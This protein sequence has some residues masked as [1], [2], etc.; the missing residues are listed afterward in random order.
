MNKVKERMITCA[1][2]LVVAFGIG[3]MNYGGSDEETDP[4]ITVKIGKEVIQLEQGEEFEADAWNDLYVF[5][6]GK[7][8]S[9]TPVIM[10]DITIGSTIEEVSQVFGLNKDNAKINAEV[11]TEEHDGTT[12]VIDVEYSDEFFDENNEYL[13]GLI[14]FGFNKADGQ[15]SIV[16]ADQIESAELVYCIDINGMSD[17]S[18][19]PG[20]VIKMSIKHN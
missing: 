2:I 8:Y 16:P 13:D 7:D 17:S 11:P 12:D 9:D 10:G 5:A 19:Q 18:V 3:F 20:Q 14:A 1:I 6:K 15:W 4:Y